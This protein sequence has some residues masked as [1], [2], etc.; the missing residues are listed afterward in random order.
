MALL[1]FILAL[2]WLERG[3]FGWKGL[4]KQ[5]SPDGKFVFFW[6]CRVCFWE[7]RFYGFLRRLF[8]IILR[9][10]QGLIFLVFSIR[11]CFLCKGSFFCLEATFIFFIRIL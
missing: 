7:K 10:R 5:W 11:V 3:Y 6:D 1:G 2:I 4:R 8:T 9:Q